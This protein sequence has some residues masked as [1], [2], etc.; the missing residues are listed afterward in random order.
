[1]KLEK[2]AIRY[3]IITLI[4]TLLIVSFIANNSFAAG[5]CAF[6]AGGNFASKLAVEDAVL[7]AKTYYSNMGYR[8]YYSVKP[9]QSILTGYFQNGTRRLESDI[10][11]LDG[12]GSLESIEISDGVGIGMYPAAGQ[13]S[14]TS[15]FNWENTKLVV[16]LACKTGQD[17]GMSNI[18]YDIWVKSGYKN[19]TIGWKQ[20]IYTPSSTPWANRFNY[21]LSTGGT[22]RNAIDYAN[23]FNDYSNNSIK[24]LAFYGEWGTVLK[25]SSRTNINKVNSDE[26]DNVK[27]IDKSIEFNGKED[28]NNIINLMNDEY[29]DFDINNFEISVFNLD[30]SNENYTIDLQYKVG[31]CYTNQGY[32]VAVENAKVSKITNNMLPNA[33]QILENRKLEVTEE[34]IEEL[35]LKAI[36]D[37]KESLSS[38]EKEKVSITKQEY[39]KIFDEK[40]NTIKII[41]STAYTF[42]NIT[43]GGVSY[44]YQL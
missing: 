39:K 29:I 1:M 11:F 25:Q 15:D 41:I 3:L 20:T 18:T 42:N 6:S 27:H 2:K 10:V 34:K 4:L 44:E 37:L 13:P 30:S 38:E 7:N 40:S 22:L 17:I 23:G 19:I 14:L 9:T 24:D 28:I 36:E 32:V 12:H 26:I 35:K 21:R 43:E 5:N 33:C 31:D 8:S 16:L